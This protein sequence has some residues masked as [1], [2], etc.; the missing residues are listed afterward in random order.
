MVLSYYLI[1]W[2]YTLVW[3]AKK[4]MNR[5]D[6]IVFYCANALDY[7]IFLPVQKHLPPLRIV[8]RNKKVQAEL[9][10]IGI[11]SVV[12]PVFPD[13]VI[14]CRQAG[15]KFP[16]PGIVRIGMRHGAYTFK[17][18][19]NV[20]SYNLLTHFYMTSSHE[21]ERA[22]SIGI[23][24]GIAIGF[25]KLDPAFDGSSGP[26]ALLHYRQIAGITEKKPCVLFTSTWNESDVSAVE[27]WF[28]K[29][30]L[31][32]R[33]YQV[34]VTV[35]PWTSASIKEKIKQTAGVYFIDT[36]DVLPYIQISN[37]CIGDT[38]SILAECCALDKPMITFKL[39]DGKRTVLEVKALIAEFSHQIE[40]LDQLMPAIEEALANPGKRSESR[41]KANKI[42]FDVLDGKAGERAAN[43]I[44]SLFQ[45]L[46]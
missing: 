44:K 19:A 26:D 39:P 11:E 17:P 25:P 15:Y 21:V 24:S 9:N 34:L 6:G 5:T 2:P 18:F 41:E 43:H 35:H 32:T 42:M 46:K 4:L 8:A 31:F 40:N 37:V 29:L 20:K 16:A 28:D 33:K 22:K 3:V 27:L 14:M 10:A 30:S 38:S 36:P 23:K 1:K 45:S 12:Y 7:Q 13:G